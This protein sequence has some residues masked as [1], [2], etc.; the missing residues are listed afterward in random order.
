VK[1]SIVR[2]GGL[3]G[4]ARRTELH[5]DALPEDAA[6]AL[7]AHAAAVCPLPA[8]GDAPPSPARDE[9]RY[10]VCVECAGGTTEAHYTDTTLPDDVR[11]LIAWADGRP[12]R[13]DELLR[14]GQS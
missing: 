3:A 5:T 8:P 6:R 9:L 14:P 1:L 12:E 13:Q 7:E 4:V 10:T 2:G 11:A